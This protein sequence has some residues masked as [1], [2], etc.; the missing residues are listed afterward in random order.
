MKILMFSADPGAEGRM[1]KYG[2]LLEKLEIVYFDRSRG[3]FSRFWKGYREAKRILA[4]EKFD[5]ITAQE[6]EHSFLAWRLSK[7][8]KVPWQ[9]QIHT[10]IFSRYFARE[11][12]LNMARVWLAK[13]LLPRASC[14]RV[15][16]ER[17]KK[18]LEIRNW[19]LEIS[20]LP[21][22]AELKNFGEQNL[23]EKYPGYDF[24]ILMVGRLTWE[25]NFYLALEVMR[26]VIKIFN[27]LLVIV[28]EGN[29]RGR[30]E[31]EVLA[32]L[33]ANVKFEG[34][35]EN[36]FGY[37]QTSDTLLLTSDY[38]GYGMAVVE[39]IQN[40]LPVIMS[41]VGVAGEIIKN[42]E[43]GI[44]VPVGDK[45]KFAEAILRLKSNE[46]LRLRLSQNAKNTKLPYN[47]FEEYRDKLI[48]SFKQCRI[49]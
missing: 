1:R 9:M 8:F 24:Y 7:K 4:R 40:G 22:Y 31:C 41:D 45:D 14:V 23:K 46:S 39:A 36:L 17:I 20:V 26:E 12:F 25:K 32:G 44:I 19:K 37:Y 3:R 29:E 43:N 28:G 33:E 11:S 42:D 21:I 49:R 34:W 48:M 13:F 38:E 10:D 5:L 16:S 27:P 47:S 15:V 30:L 6:I 2:E 18:S 35:Q